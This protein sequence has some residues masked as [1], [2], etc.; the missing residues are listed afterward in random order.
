MDQDRQILTAA[1]RPGQPGNPAA[2]APEGAAGSPAPEA[3]WRQNRWQD[4]VGTGGR[5]TPEYVVITSEP[6]V[7]LRAAPRKLKSSTPSNENTVGVDDNVGGTE[8]R[9]AIRHARLENHM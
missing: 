5:I 9:D 1:V 2:R 4:Q 7:H 3:G 6:A 8:R